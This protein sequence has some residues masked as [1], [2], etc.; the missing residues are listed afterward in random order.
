MTTQ[1]LYISLM[2]AFV[3]LILMT[4]N[5]NAKNNTSFLSGLVITL[6]GIFCLVVLAITI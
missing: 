2:I 1:H 4:I 3:G 5:T 6:S